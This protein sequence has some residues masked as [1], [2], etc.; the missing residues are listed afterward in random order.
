MSYGSPQGLDDGMPYGTE[1]SDCFTKAQW[2]RMH[3]D[4]SNTVKVTVTAYPYNKSAETITLKT[5]S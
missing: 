1:H 4:T 5:A 2:E 3:E